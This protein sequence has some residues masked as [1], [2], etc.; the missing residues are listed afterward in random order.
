MRDAWIAKYSVGRQRTG[1][2]LASLLFLAVLPGTAVKNSNIRVKVLDS[3][4]QSFITND[5]PIPINCDMLNYDAYCHSSKTEEVINTLLVQ[6]NDQP[7]HRVRCV[8]ETKWSRCAQLMKG[9]S[10]D[11][12]PERNGLTI[13]YLDAQGKLRKQLYTYVA[14]EPK[15]VLA[16]V[17]AGA[18]EAVKCSFT[19]TPPGAEVSVDG[20][21]V[22]STPSIVNVNTGEHEVMVSMPGFAQWKK[23]LGVSSGSQLTVNAILERVQAR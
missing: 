17:P 11:A 23:E 19:S 5:N 20:H 6:V 9:F 14:D 21:Y 4:R 8:V 16:P 12:V 22:G 15:G 3:E 2:L 10:F 13:Y 18:A 7:P 1:I